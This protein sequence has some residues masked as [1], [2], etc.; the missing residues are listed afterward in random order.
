[1][2]RQIILKNNGKFAVWSS[3]VDDFIFDDITKEEYIEFRKK[4]ECERI[5]KDLLD[6]FISLAEG[7]PE[8]NYYQFVMSYEDACKLRDEI[9]NKK[10]D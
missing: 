5:E 4:E 2:G 1:M 9:H 6:I 3:I 7:E 8:R 10:N